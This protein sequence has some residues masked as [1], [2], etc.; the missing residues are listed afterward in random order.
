MPLFPGVQPYLGIESVS[1]VQVSTKNPIHV[2]AFFKYPVRD[3]VSV[4]PGIIYLGNP[5]QTGDSEDQII[6]TI[7]T[8]FT[9]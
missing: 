7:R 6:T 2:E 1:G 9:F 8:T 4:T 3:N 5:E